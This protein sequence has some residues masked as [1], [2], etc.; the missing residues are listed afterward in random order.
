LGGGNQDLECQEGD[1]SKVI[2]KES[3]FNTRQKLGES[4]W[5]PPGKD[6]L[7]THGAGGKG[8]GR[9]DWANKVTGNLRD[10]VKQT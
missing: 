9:E 7:T 5:K 6:I 3:Y 1:T 10:K 2:E 8:Y 4:G